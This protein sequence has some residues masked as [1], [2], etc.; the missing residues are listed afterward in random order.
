MI[1]M[2][3]HELVT[4]YLNTGNNQHFAQLYNRH[5]HRVYQKCYAYTGNSDDSEDF[6]QEIFVR[7]TQ[8]LN[9]YKGDAKFT[10]WLH[11]VTVNYCLDQIRKKQHQQAMWCK[12]LFEASPTTE[13]VTSTSEEPYITASEKVLKQL[14]PTQ[15]N[16]LVT[17]YGDSMSIKDIALSQRITSSA[18]KMRIKRARDHARTLYDKALAEQDH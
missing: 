14:T 10:T 11:V 18:V 16:L 8:K 13:W 9:S 15:R 1:N 6:V 12:Y 4:L 2:S 7:L 5:R 3:D 17:K